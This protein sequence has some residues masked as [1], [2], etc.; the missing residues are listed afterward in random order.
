M[1]DKGMVWK[2]AWNRKRGTPEVAPVNMAFFREFL[3][4]AGDAVNRAIYETAGVSA[5]GSTS[6]FWFGAVG[7]YAGFIRALPTFEVQT[8]SVV[9]L[10]TAVVSLIG[11][12]S[13]TDLPVNGADFICAV[14][15]SVTPDDAGGC[16][17]AVRVDDQVTA[18]GSAVAF[19]AVTD[20]ILFSPGGLPGALHG[21]CG[22]QGTTP[23]QLEVRQWFRDLKTN[24]AI[25]EIPG[26]T[27]HRYSAASAFPLVPTPLPNLGSAGAAQDLTLTTLSGTPVPTNVLLPVRFPY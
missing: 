18:F 11:S 13:E 3:T 27:T 10:V 4:G 12:V 17:V 6:T 20:P 24:L 9:D 25:Q 21:F 2:T 1:T 14:L 16:R 8:T 19:S 23:T 5:L 26:K 22:G 15:V 7:V